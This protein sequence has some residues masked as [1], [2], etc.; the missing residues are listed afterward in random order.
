MLVNYLFIDMLNNY[1]SSIKL[2]RM[3]L[4]KL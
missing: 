3:L 4:G 1:F 2:A